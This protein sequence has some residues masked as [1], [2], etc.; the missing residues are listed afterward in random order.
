MVYHSENPREF[1]FLVLHVFELRGD[2]QECYLPRTTGVMFKYIP[3]VSVT[4]VSYSFKHKLV[5]SLIA[6][7]LLKKI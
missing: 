6:I 3:V 1:I 4:L 2:L 7:S 5:L